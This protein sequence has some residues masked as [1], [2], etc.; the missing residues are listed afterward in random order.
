MKKHDDTNQRESSG[1]FT[2]A[3]PVDSNKEDEDR[4]RR[5]SKR[6]E[7]DRGKS[8]QEEEKPEE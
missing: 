5:H 6:Q 8:Q 7:K 4:G 1:K 3:D 2:P